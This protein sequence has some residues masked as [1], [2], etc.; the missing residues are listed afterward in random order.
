VV[1]LEFPESRAHVLQ[2][3]GRN[4]QLGATFVE[5]PSCGRIIATIEKLIQKEGLGYVAVSEQVVWPLSSGRPPA[6]GEVPDSIRQDYDEAA[7]VLPFSAKASAALSRRCL[8]AVLRDAGKTKGKHLSNQIREVLPALPTYI[9]NNLDI[10]RNIGNFATHEQ[11]STSTGTILDVESGE[12]EWNLEVLDALFDFYY[13]KPAVE[14]A[15]R[16]ELEKKLADAG[17][18]PLKKP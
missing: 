13:V 7:L 18:P 1:Q 12:A 16:A 11:K 10:I 15:K 4:E 8:Q 14:A 9:A 17:K 6:P 5:C 2:V 3:V